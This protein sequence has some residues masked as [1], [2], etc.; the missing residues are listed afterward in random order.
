[1][2]VLATVVFG[3]VAL[4]GLAQHEMQ[5]GGAPGAD[6]LRSGLGNVHHAVS[7]SNPL[8][9][10]YFDQGLALYYGFNHNAAIRSFREAGVLDPNLAMAH[11]GVALAL[12]PNINAPIDQAGESQAYAELQQAQSLEAHASRRERALIDALAARYTGDAKPDFDKLSMDYRHAMADVARSYPDDPDVQTLYAESIMD[13]HP[14]QMWSI[15]GKPNEG[16]EECIG[17]LRGVLA[18]HPNHI[19]ANHFLVHVLEASPH[20]EDA[21]E[22][23][24]RLAK[25]APNSGHLVHMPSHIY[26]RTGLYHEGVLANEK[27]LAVDERFLSH[28]K[29]VGMYPMYY[30]HNFDMLRHAANMEGNFAKSEAAAE[31]V[32]DKVSHLEGMPAPEGA[33]AEAALNMYRFRKWHELLDYEPRGDGLSLALIHFAKAAAY[34]SSDRMADAEREDAA[35]ELE[36]GKL[37]AS[38]MYGF[39]PSSQILGICEHLYEATLARRDH[40]HEKEV[41][42]LES[43][44]AIQDQLGY[45]EPPDFFYPV[46]E[47][48]GGALL[49]AKKPQEAEAVFREDLKRNPKNGRSLFGLSIALKTDGKNEEAARTG[50]EFEDAW[51]WADTKLSLED[52]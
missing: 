36:K 14:W 41:K 46:R 16:T 20:P 4:T 33:Q 26:I 39:N 11:W 48:L 38:S 23:A 30:I 18:S 24:K 25:L 37:P 42:E 7:T 3:C 32:V 5:M 52:L 35:M 12:G 10:K 22:A 21:L 51:R 13:T 17:T 44:V 8:A 43:A 31:Q 19:G 40:D 27:A 49:R 45:D 29:D 34:A 50:R 28:T 9:Q 6:P 1:M 47:S 15:D 2:R